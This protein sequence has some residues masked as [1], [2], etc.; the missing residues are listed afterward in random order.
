MRNTKALRKALYTKIEIINKFRQLCSSYVTCS[1]R[2]AA[3]L[4]H[5]SL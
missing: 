2:I 3:G 4:N 1:C 5:Y